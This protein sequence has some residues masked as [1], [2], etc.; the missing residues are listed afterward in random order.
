MTD[1]RPLIS[2]VTPT[3]NEED[4]VEE[5]CRRIKAVM[6]KCGVSD[7]E[8]IFIDNASTGSP[9]MSTSSLCRKSS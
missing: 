5:A 3:F 1:E 2:I 9:L 7:Y 6:E 4:N 8:H